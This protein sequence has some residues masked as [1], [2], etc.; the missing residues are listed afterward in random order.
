MYKLRPGL[1]C[2]C[3][4]RG[5]C[6]KLYGEEYHDEF[7]FKSGPGKNKQYQAKLLRQYKPQGRL[8]DY[9]CGDASFLASLE[10]YGYD[11]NG[12]EYDPRLVDK[13]CKTH[14]GIK[15]YTIPSLEYCGKFHIIHLCD[16]RTSDRPQGTETLRVTWRPWNIVCGEPG[17]TYFHILYLFRAG[18]FR[19]RKLFQP[20]RVVNGKPFRV[21]FSTK[22]NQELFFTNNGYTTLHLELFEW[23][24]P[25]PD[26]WKDA[27]SLKQK[28]AFML[29][30][31]SK[32][33]SKGI[34]RWGNRFYYVGTPTKGQ[35]SSAQ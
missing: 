20:N 1:S 35:G 26:H 12:A 2:S 25:F 31:V 18:Y 29:G 30:A 13:L 22:K 8:L 10:Q 24:W 3:A 9:G 17:G 19:L 32:S 28:M 7:Y 34:K 15:F 4:H 11:L 16:A 27:R 14:P 23:A 33:F 21:M 6:A 5:R